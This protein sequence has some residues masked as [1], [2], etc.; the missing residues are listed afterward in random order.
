[1]YDIGDIADI[2]DIANTASSSSSSSNN[3]NNINNINNSSHMKELLEEQRSI[4]RL[5]EEQ[6]SLMRTHVSQTQ[7]LMRL[8][9][10]QHSPQTIT[11]R[12][13]RMKGTHTPITSGNRRSQPIGTAI[14]TDNE[15]NAAAVR[16]SSSLSEIV[17]DIRSFEVEG[18]EETEHVAGNTYRRPLSFATPL[19]ANT[20]KISPV[21]STG[22]L[23]LV[24]N[25][26]TDATSGAS[27][28]VSSSS[29]GI[30]GLVSRINN[31]VSESKEG[32]AGNRQKSNERPP[33]MPAAT[34]PPPGFAMPRRLK[35]TPTT[36]KYLDSLNQHK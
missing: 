7:E 1:N 15:S 13:L 33:I 27:R 20:S 9:Q 8:A 11:R 29:N 35:V 28:I 34:K 25:G 2:A 5:L 22:L 19:C 10:H 23:S 14:E 32:S 36:Q 24:H 21:E 26:K 31:L 30:T 4:R 6:N 3:N 16:R 12:Y 18:Y 17:G